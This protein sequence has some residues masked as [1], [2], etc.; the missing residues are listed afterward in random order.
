MVQAMEHGLEASLIT[1]TPDASPRWASGPLS[2][3]LAKY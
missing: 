3:F 1:E 2:N